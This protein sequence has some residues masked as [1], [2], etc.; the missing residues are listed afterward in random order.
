MTSLTTSDAQ[1]APH[2]PPARRVAGGTRPSASLRLL[3]DVP[4]SPRRR[5]SRLASSR[6]Q[7]G[8]LWISSQPLRRNLISNF[9]GSGWSALLGL[10]VLP[11]CLRLPGVEAYGLVGIFATLLSMLTPLEAGRGAMGRRYKDDVLI[12]AATALAVVLA[13]RLLL[14]AGLDRFATFLYLAA[15]GL[16]SFTATVLVTPASRSL[17]LTRMK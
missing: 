6:P 17:L 7:R 5:A 3:R 11:V 8:P 12:A 13:A 10:I 2:P 14:P 4:A 1:I 15:T 16:V 9:A